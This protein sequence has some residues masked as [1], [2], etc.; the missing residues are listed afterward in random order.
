MGI[1]GE[2]VEKHALKN[3][4]YTAQGFNGYFK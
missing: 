3:F 1:F 4:S 2:F